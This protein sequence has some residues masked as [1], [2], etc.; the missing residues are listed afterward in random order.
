MKRVVIVH[1]EMGIFIGAGMGITFWSL[2]E[3]ANQ[4]T[5]VC[6]SDELEAR[7]FVK[8]WVP[9]QNPD[10]YRYVQINS[11]GGWATVKEL[12]K[13]GLGKMTYGLLLNMPAEGI[14]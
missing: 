2:L 13:A 1:D 8:E 10:N 3:C 14:A 5:V 9:P 7:E 11:A 12:T 6:F 4:S